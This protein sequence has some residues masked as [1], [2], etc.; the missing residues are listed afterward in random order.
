MA[1]YR[2]KRKAYRLDFSETEYE[3]LEVTVRGLT[4]GEYLDL[5]RLSATS[6]D[7]GDTE[8]EGMLHMFADHL[9]AWNL[10]DDEGP[11]ATTYESVVENDFTMNMAIVSAWMDALAAVPD[12]TEKKSS[13]GAN[14]LVAS[15]PMETL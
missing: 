3:G 14:P 11:V 10:E 4:T 7:D 6:N 1:G 13:A 12:K 9:V 2:R 8:T 5:V 15:I